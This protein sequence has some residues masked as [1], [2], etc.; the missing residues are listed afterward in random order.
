[1]LQWTETLQQGFYCE[2]LTGTCCGKLE[3]SLGFDHLFSSFT[4]QKYY[5]INY[6]DD[7]L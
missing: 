3:I 7:K 6:L 2:T 1:M 5:F 4:V